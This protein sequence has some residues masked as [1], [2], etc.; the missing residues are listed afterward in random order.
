[1]PSIYQE[2]NGSNTVIDANSNM[3][4]TVN[5]LDISPACSALGFT[6]FSIE[7]QPQRQREQC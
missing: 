2:E 4:L 3:G 7:G 5:W 1:M 6:H